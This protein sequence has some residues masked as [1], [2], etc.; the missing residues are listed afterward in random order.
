VK[1]K[2]V[3]ILAAAVLGAAGAVVLAAWLLPPSLTVWWLSLALLLLSLGLAWAAW[4]STTL[5][6]ANSLL[7]WEAVEQKRVEQDLLERVALLDLA[8]DAI[9]MRDLEDRIVY[10][11]KGAERLYGWTAEEALGENAIELLFQGDPP[12]LDEARQIL[13]QN[14]EWVG[15]WHQVTKQGRAIVA[16]TRWTLV[17]DDKGQ[18]RCILVVNTDVTE[19]VQLQAQLLRTQRLESIGVLAGSVAHDFNNLLNPILM[20][21]KLLREERPEEE[22][23]HLLT[24]LQTSAE[25]GAE[26]VRQLLSFAGGSSGERAPVKVKHLIKEVKSIIDHTFP[27]TIRLEVKLADN[28]AAVFADETQ[29]SQVL[30]NLCVNARDAMP[31]GGRMTIQAENVLIDADAARLHAD[32]RPGAYLQIKVAD[33]GTGIAPQIIDRIFDPF[34]TTKEQGKGTGLGLSTVLGIVKSHHGFVM[35]DS[36]PGKGSQFTVCL[37]ALPQQHGDKAGPVRPTP[38]RGRG[39]LILLVDD[40]VLILETVAPVLKS[41]GYRVM[42]ATNGKEALETWKEHRA[43]IKAVVLDMMMPVLDGP[44]T[45]SAL[46]EMDPQVRVIATSGLRPTGWLMDELAAGKVSFL[47]KPYSDEQLLT[48]LARVLPA[49]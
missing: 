23:Q 13:F 33:T 38:P 42:T 21:V 44:G 39:E 46:Q 40:E 28:L 48:T 27:K 19:R 6:R 22:R 49:P 16:E 9:T 1:D 8:H 11:N 45:L 29:L 20:A 36:K 37:P 4:N 26:I 17:R 24:T 34:F 3:G 31:A 14:G 10:W 25:R 30:M 2:Q 15:D 12:R 5:A 41:H 35:L 32:A 43:Q 47:A 18:P 7:Q